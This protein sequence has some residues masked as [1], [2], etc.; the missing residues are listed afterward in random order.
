MPMRPVPRFF[1]IFGI[2]FGLLFTIVT[3][4]LWIDRATRQVAFVTGLLSVLLFLVAWPAWRRIFRRRIPPSYQRDVLERDLGFEQ[5][6]EVEG[7]QFAVLLLP[8]PLP[9]PS[10]GVL[11]LAVQNAHA[12]PALFT[13]GITRSPFHLDAKEARIPLKPGEARIVTLPFFAAAGLG[14]SDAVVKYITRVDRNAEY[15]ARVIR[16]KGGP[17]AHAGG[18]TYAIVTLGATHTGPEPAGPHFKGLRLDE[19]IFATGQAAPNLSA[20]ELILKTG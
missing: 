6:T 12:S 20:V 11:A 18:R 8:D 7:V 3:V 9:L 19:T 1:S 16:R 15:G 2:S 13:L 10:Y 17:G 4:A 5:V 14:T